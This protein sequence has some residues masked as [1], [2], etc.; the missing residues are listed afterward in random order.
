MESGSGQKQLG[1]RR[2]AAQRKGFVG[3]TAERALF[4]SATGGETVPTQEA[5]AERLGLPLSTYRRHL[6]RGTEEVCARLWSQ[7]LYGAD[8]G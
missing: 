4:R 3:R 2:R 7:E 5:A 8:T 1:E 6:S